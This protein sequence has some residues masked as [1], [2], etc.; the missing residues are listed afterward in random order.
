MLFLWQ[1]AF[2]AEK[3]P[4]L[5]SPITKLL[6][7]TNL[8]EKTNKE[9]L[10]WWNQ[11][12]TNIELRAPLTITPNIKCQAVIEI[13]K[14]ERYEQLPVVTHAGH[15]LGMVTLPHLMAKMVS[16]KI[17]P[18]SPVSD[19]VLAD[20][21]KKVELTAN[22]K[23]LSRVLDRDCFA[24]VVR[25]QT[26]YSSDSIISSPKEVIFGLV[27]RMDLLNY[28]S[29]NHPEPKP[30]EDRPSIFEVDCPVRAMCTC[31]ARRCGSRYG[32]KADLRRKVKQML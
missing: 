22:L 12:I 8:I 10:W 1:L 26:L 23:D 13:M 17:T 5:Q 32:S 16:G 24:L 29:T 7:E 11:K 30:L 18:D 19:C 25:S 3:N 6:E 14:K 2:L 9:D 4:Q 28:I 20:N 31:K 15:V 27:T 21:F